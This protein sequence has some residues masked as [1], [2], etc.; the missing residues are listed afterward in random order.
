M[1]HI[2][3]TYANIFASALQDNGK[4]LC[5][6]YNRNKPFEN[7]IYQV[8]NAVDYASTGDTPYT[9]AQVVGIAFQLVFQTGLFN[10]DY[11]L[12]QRHPADVKTWTHP[13]EFLDTSHQE[14]WESQ[15][16]TASS[17]FQLGNHAYQLA[18]HAYQNETVK[19]ISNLD[20]ATA[21][22]CSLVAALTATNSTLTAD[23]T[24]TQSQIIIAL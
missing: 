16:T 19:A 23:C 4:R 20:K 10:D 11:N 12:W 21:S 6:P 2:Y 22:D 9:P 24:A 3:S 7:L 8:E 1:G 18:N 17:V 14:W 13:K 15:T 5:A